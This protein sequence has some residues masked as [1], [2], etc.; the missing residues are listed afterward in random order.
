MKRK[1]LWLT[2]SVSLVFNAM[3]VAGYW[4]ASHDR[5]GRRSF[6]RRT[7]WMAHHLGLE[8]EQ[9]EAFDQVAEEIA[10]QREQMR[11]QRREWK[12]QLMEELGKD[13]PDDAAIEQLITEAFT[14]QRAREMVSQMR[15]LMDVLT[16]EQRQKCLELMRERWTKR[17]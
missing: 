4:Q 17:S 14:P 3:F 16:P 11:S 8:G 2:L 1:W 15:R 5:G 7:Q 9:R 13:E 10:K 6:E 12:Q